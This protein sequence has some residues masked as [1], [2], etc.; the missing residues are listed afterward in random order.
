MFPVL[1]DFDLFGFL[2]DPWSLHTYGVLIAIGFISA[3]NLAKR[4]AER[5]GEDPDRIVDLAFYVLLAGLVGSRIVFIF[6]KLD[7]YLKDPIEIVMFWRGG[8]VWYGGFIAA[9]MY[10]WTYCRKHRLNFFKYADICIPYVA[11]AHAAG[12]LGCLAA[13]CCFGA[14]SSMPWAVVFPN[15]SMAQAAHQSDGLV[16]IGD[17]SL[18]VHPT[19][20]YEAGGEITMFWVLLLLRSSKRFHGQLLLVWLAVYP[21]MRSIIEV[22][23]GDKER[24]IWLLGMSTSQWISILVAGSAVWLFWHLRRLRMRAELPAAVAVS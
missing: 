17:A 11:L 22:Y 23:R 13:G 21:I 19:Q 6:T 12:R 20:L 1:H 10:V 3:M 2:K 14:P 18:A 15:G 16:A 24:G 5:E 4:Q 8:L 7:Q 9:T